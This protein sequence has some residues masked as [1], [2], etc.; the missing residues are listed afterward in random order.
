MK[1]LIVDLITARCDLT[2][3]DNVECLRVRLEENAME[4]ACVP[5][6]LIK[7]LRLRKKQEGS[8]SS[9]EKKGGQS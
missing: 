8:L 5:N 3:R 9:P 7:L 1:V 2:G 6:E 4:I